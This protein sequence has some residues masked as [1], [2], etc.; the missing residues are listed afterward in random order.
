MDITDT[1]PVKHGQQHMIPYAIFRCSV[2]V[3]YL[4]TNYLA[5]LY[6]NSILQTQAE[7]GGMVKE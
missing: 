1:V 3:L 5:I 2:I 6:F 7:M 4:G